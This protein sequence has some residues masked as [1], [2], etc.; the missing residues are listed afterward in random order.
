MLVETDL[1]LNPKLKIAA[2]ILDRA[3]D[4]RRPK[5]S[6]E[7]VAHSVSDASPPFTI[8]MYALGVNGFDYDTSKAGDPQIWHADVHPSPQ[9]TRFG[10]S[11]IT[12]PIGTRRL[13]VQIDKNVAGWN[14]PT[15]VEIDF[16]NGIYFDFTVKD[17]DPE[18]NSRGLWALIQQQLQAWQ[19][20]HEPTYFQNP[21]NTSGIAGFAERVRVYGFFGALHGFTNTVD[22]DSQIRSWYDYNCLFSVLNDWSPGAI[23]S[24]QDVD[25]VTLYRGTQDQPP[26]PTMATTTGMAVPAYVGLAHIVFDQFALANFGNRPP[27]L[28]FEVVRYEN[29]RVYTV[30]E[31]LCLEAGVPDASFDL[32]QVE[33][34]G[35]RAETYV[36]GYS[37]GNA[38]TYRAVIEQLLEAF[39]LDAAEINNALVFRPL[40]REIDH[41]IPYSDLG[42]MEAGNEPKDLLQITSTDIMEMPQ[43]LEVVFTDAARDYQTNSAMFARL[44][45]ITQQ[46]SSTQIPI[47]SNPAFMR[48]WVEK[49]MQRS[50]VERAIAQ[51]SLPHRHI[52]ISPTDIIQF[53]K[54]DPSLDYAIASFEIEAWKKGAILTGG[55]DATGVNGQ[56]SNLCGPPALGLLICN[57]GLVPSIA[58]AGDS[59][60][61]SGVVNSPLLYTDID[62]LEFGIPRQA[63][64]DGM[65]AV[66]FKVTGE[67]GA[68]GDFGAHDIGIIGFGENRRGK[69]AI[70]F[71]GRDAGLSKE[72]AFGQVD[73]VFGGEVTAV[74][75]AQIE[76][77]MRFVRT[78]IR[79]VRADVIWSASKFTIESHVLYRYDPMPVYDG[80]TMRVVSVTRG[81]NGVLEVEGAIID[82]PVRQ[83][84]IDYTQYSGGQSFYVAPAPASLVLSPTKF[85]GLNLP[86]LSEADNNANFYAAMTGTSNK[87]EGATLYR[88]TDGSSSFQEA[89]T[90]ETDCV[91]GRVISGGLLPNT[92]AGIPD[93]DSTVTVEL[94]NSDTSLQSIATDRLFNGGNTA[95]IGKEIVSFLLVESLGANKYKLYGGMLRGRLGTDRPE[96]MNTHTTGEDFVLLSDA[97]IIDIPDTTQHM[98]TAFPYKAVTLNGN[99]AEIAANAFTNTCER[100]KPFHPVQLSSVRDTVTGDLTISWVRQDRAHYAW[101]DFAD[102]ATSEATEAYQV[103]VLSPTATVSTVVRTIDVVGTSHFVYTAGDQAMDGY[104]V[105]DAVTV[106]VYQMSA[107]VGRG[108]GLKGNVK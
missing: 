107:T 3:D 53:Q 15:P 32:S 78:Y 34:L 95:L 86:M 83:Q 43:Q 19:A 61:E 57:N 84:P 9:G 42:A 47:V 33:L 97:A 45:V 73:S 108:A 41:A 51:G 106:V 94:Y 58:R 92:S 75:S 90:T 35:E 21:R 99:P 16:Q 29:D 87:W 70:G 38:T 96:C 76:P 65:V 72:I 1:T 7:F 49:K 91:I 23:L 104:T 74:I 64:D 54:G 67:Q 14:T 93:M 80:A 27:N 13:R 103:E 60:Y 22:R 85:V 28:S 44:E 56:K 12:L 105:G 82:P 48:R 4:N 98:N 100:L 37:I 36:A 59:I 39:R 20:E 8:R 10:A 18:V 66:S 46:K 30:I 6:F 2:T 25:G 50:W 77:G 102:L 40:D 71:E 24:F 89:G 101:V 31:T 26:D 17:S 52:Y 63:I 68:L 88:S 62:L 79:I 11:D 5:I 81:A 69:M 55:V